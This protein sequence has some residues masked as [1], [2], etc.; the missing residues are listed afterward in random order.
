VRRDGAALRL[1]DA[2]VIVDS[3]AVP[4]LLATPL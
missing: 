4:T 1:V 3:F 2:L